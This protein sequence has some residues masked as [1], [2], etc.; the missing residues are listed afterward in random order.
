MADRSPETANWDRI[1]F[2]LF[3]AGRSCDAACRVACRFGSHMPACLPACL[4]ISCILYQ[5]VY[6]T[7][8]FLLST[9]PI[10]LFI[11][12]FEILDATRTAKKDR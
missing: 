4:H 6:H 7:G 3:L 1:D 9:A 12:K 2:N 10:Y 8:S 11:F 5:T